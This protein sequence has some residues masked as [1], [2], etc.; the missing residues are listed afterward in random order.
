MK[1][2]IAMSTYNGEKFIREQLDSI[3]SQTVQDFELI[4][5]DD[6]SSDSTVQILNEY[7]KKDARIKVFVNKK[8]LGF[9][10]NF[11]KAISLCSGE[12]IALSDQDDV[13]TENHLEL[14][15][16]NLG[17]SNLIGGGAFLVDAKGQSLNSTLLES[18][19]VNWFP[20]ENSDCWLDFLF[21]RN[22]FQGTAIL[23]KANF[24]KS[25]LPIPEKVKFHD[26]WF[27]L[28]AAFEKKIKYLNEIVLNYRQHGN[29]VTFNEKWNSFEKIKSTFDLKNNT[30][31]LHIDVLSAMSENEKFLSVENKIKTALNYYR[32]L[33]NGKRFENIPYFIRNY[34]FVT[35]STNIKIVFFRFMKLLLVG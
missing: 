14:L 6:C 4:T 2:S 29:N 9:T 32:N 7:E 34:K 20:A 1:V 16:K 13:W 35:G 17:T 33:K 15:L 11:E 8:N 19:G 26:W 21:H 18:A 22:I 27:A 5:C 31:Q 28:N 23:A 30:A 3:L 10:R 25:C 12:Y 24:I